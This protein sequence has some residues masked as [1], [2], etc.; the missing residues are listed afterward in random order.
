MFS[1]TALVA[2][3]VV[4]MVSLVGYVLNVVKLITM[5]QNANANYPLF[6]VRVIG[7]FVPFVGIVM[8]FVK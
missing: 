3:F 8:G 7:I 6:A 5:I 4:C 1:I 2:F